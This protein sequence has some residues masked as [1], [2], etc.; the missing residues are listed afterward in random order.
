MTRSLK[1]RGAHAGPVK[2]GRASLKLADWSRIAS[3]DGRY[4]AIPLH[5]ERLT[6]DSQN[7]GTQQGALNEAFFQLRFV[8]DGF[9]LKPPAID[10]SYLA[11]RRTRNNFS[12]RIFDAHIS[13]RH[14]MHFFE[15]SNALDSV[16]YE[17][18]THLRAQT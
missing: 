7:A 17:R 3:V 1:T 10:N 6:F 18:D 15:E 14:V 8:L 2:L 4:P 11:F 12:A 5:C 16:D 13:I 9:V